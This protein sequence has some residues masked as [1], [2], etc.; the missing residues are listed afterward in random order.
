MNLF[1]SALFPHENR[2]EG[3]SALTL[4]S[5]RIR[6]KEAV[7]TQANTLGSPFGVRVLTR[8]MVQFHSNI[9]LVGLDFRFGIDS[10]VAP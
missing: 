3:L 7:L 1:A 8:Q 6:M 2:D 9:G 10:F 5:G 4:F